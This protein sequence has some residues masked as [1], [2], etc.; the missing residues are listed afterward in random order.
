MGEWSF[1]M[2]RRGHRGLIWLFIFIVAPAMG[3]VEPPVFHMVDE[4]V[5]FVDTAAVFTL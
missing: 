1:G 2:R 4:A 3:D 5:L